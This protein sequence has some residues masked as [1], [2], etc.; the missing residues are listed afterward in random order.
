MLQ[1]KN[2]DNIYAGN[3]VTCDSCDKCINSGSVW[4]CSNENQS[5]D[6][7]HPEG[8]D[9]CDECLKLGKNKYWHANCRCY[10]Y[11]QQYRYHPLCQRCRKKMIFAYNS[12]KDARCNGCNKNVSGWTW[13]CR[14]ESQHSNFCWNCAHSNSSK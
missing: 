14:K 9:L 10:S 7:A 6:A 12:F 8:F 2:I 5:T 11:H 13:C 3:G 1:F 4:H